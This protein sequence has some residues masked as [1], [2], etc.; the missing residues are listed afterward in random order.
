MIP[1]PPI[2]AVSYN[3]TG[4][5]GDHKTTRLVGA[6]AGPGWVGRRKAS[7]RNSVENRVGEIGRRG[8][9]LPDLIRAR[10]AE[11]GGGRPGSRGREDS[12]TSFGTGVH[13]RT[14]GKPLCAR[15]QDWAE[16]YRG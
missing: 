10:R 7:G 4:R 5:H 2:E 8:G 14:S 15:P 6:S 12:R 3:G 9:A 13:V 1:V 11:A 16:L